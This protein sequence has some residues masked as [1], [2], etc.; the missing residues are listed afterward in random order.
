MTPGRASSGNCRAS[1][2]GRSAPA[3]QKK[4]PAVSRKRLFATYAKRSWFRMTAPRG[5]I[6][7]QPF[8]K[9]GN[10]LLSHVLRR[11]TIGAGAFH[12][13]V[14][15]GIGCSH[16]AKATRPAKGLKTSGLTFSHASTW[17]LECSRCPIG[18]GS[19]NKGLSPKTLDM[20]QPH[21]RRDRHCLMRAFK[22]IELLVPVSSTPCG[23]YTPGLSTWWSSTA[24]RE[25]SFR[26][27][28]PA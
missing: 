19:A 7:P 12:G 3:T 16:P 22:P 23:A 4:A 14:R 27:G 17:I 13:R 24:L 21:P 20:A 2:K 10:D 8:G 5:A 1:R 15:N 25:Y 11:S 28:F 6:V 18:T 9:P 26:G